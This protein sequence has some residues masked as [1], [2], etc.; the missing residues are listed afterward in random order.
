VI[1]ADIVD[2]TNQNVMKFGELEEE[3][4]H[5]ELSADQRAYFNAKSHLNIYLREQYHSL[6]N[7]LWKTDFINMYSEMPKM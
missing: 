7:L 6:M 5:F 3:N 1:G 4:V 2:S